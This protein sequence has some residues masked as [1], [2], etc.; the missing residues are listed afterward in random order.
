MMTP[1]EY[2]IFR[3]KVWLKMSHDDRKKWMDRTKKGRA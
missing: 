2:S 1:E 3:N